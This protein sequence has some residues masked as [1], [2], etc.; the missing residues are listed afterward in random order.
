MSR[1]YGSVIP[2]LLG[3]Y[4]LCALSVV[5]VGVTSK[6]DCLHLS[7]AVVCSVDWFTLLVSS[8]LFSY[9]MYIVRKLA[10]DIIRKLGKKSAKN[11][12]PLVL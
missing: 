8:L 1:L 5:T 10:G 9:L 6:S 11:I 3:V 4:I 12:L 7:K 2:Y